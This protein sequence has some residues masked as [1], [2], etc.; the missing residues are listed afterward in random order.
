MACWVAQPI[1]MY[2]N[3]LVDSYF[4]TISYNHFTFICQINVVE[5]K[6]Q[7]LSLSRGGEDV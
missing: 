3:I 6:E 1:I 5:L 7:Y 2:Q 4:F